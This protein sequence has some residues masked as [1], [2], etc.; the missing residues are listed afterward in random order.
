VDRRLVISAVNP[1]DGGTFTVLR[2]FVDAACRIL[3]SE[4]EII[5]FVH[6]R[7]L[8][9]ASRARLIEIPSAKKRWL[10]RMWTEWYRFRR[11]A[12]ELHPDLWVSLHDTSPSVGVV[13][14]AV[15]CHNPNPFFATRVR[16]V[17]FQPT[18]LVFRVA[19]KWIYKINLKRNRAIIV[20]QS[21][22]RD[23]FRKWV[24]ER[25]AIIVAHPAAAAAGRVADHGALRGSRTF[26]FPTLPRPFKNV[27]LICRA[28]QELER[29]PSWN[30][31]VILTLDGTEN[32]YARWLKRRFHR[33]RTL[34][35]LGRQS[36]EQ[37]QALYGRAD[38]LLFPSRM[39]TWGL[40]ITEAKQFGLPM[41]VADLAYAKETVGSYDRVEF[42]DID[43]AAALASKMLAFHTGAFEFKP[44]IAP[45]PQQPFVSGWPALVST[46]IDA[47]R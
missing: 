9:D 36:S 39:E 35:F 20:Q 24:D 26:L 5:V 37:M 4:W 41:F 11:Y 31:E 17:L 6:D 29:Q 46:V 7:R 13:P 43:D 1:T 33:C 32:R 14:Q 21:W 30:G 22:L 45:E 3:P 34:R 47:C 12:R 2:E 44:V 18:Q 40:P 8:L 27:E 42:I 23:E 16:D 10:L 25:T 19:Y 38:C 28:V 15:Y